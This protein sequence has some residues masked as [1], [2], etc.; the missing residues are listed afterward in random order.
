MNGLL[1]VQDQT[2]LGLIG[3]CEG[4]SGSAVV[5]L[6]PDSSTYTYEQVGIVS[7]GK[8]NEGRTPSVLTNVGHEKV[9]EFI[10]KS[11]KFI[12]SLHYCILM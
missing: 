9:L 11:S 8:C 1:C 2:P 7:G 3:S 5:T 12:N 6:N 4:D 10:Y